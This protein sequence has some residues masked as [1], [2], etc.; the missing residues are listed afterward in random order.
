M[1]TQCH[2]SFEISMTD[3]VFGM[4]ITICFNHHVNPLNLGLLS[5]CSRD[6][7]GLE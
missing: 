6:V 4:G 7:Q 5:G 1:D 2:P 3:R